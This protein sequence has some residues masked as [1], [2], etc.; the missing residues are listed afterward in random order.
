MRRPRA[1]VV[2][3]NVV[4]AGLLT[5]RSTSPTAR[6]LDGMLGARFVFLISEALLARYRALLLRPAIRR[7][8]LAEKDVDRLLA[9]IARNAVVREPGGSTR[10]APDQWDQPLWDL[11]DSEP[12]T[13]LVTGDAEVRKRSAWKI[14]LLSPLELLA[15]EA[16][17]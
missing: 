1:I 5:A 15:A 9:E 3:P 10:R 2:D 14:W 17:G 11:V 4:I 12:D 6:I 7:H 13:V 8:G 16:N